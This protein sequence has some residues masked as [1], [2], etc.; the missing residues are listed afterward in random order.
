MCDFYDFG[1]VQ[2]VERV[3]KN[4]ILILNIFLEEEAKFPNLYVT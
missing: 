2:I 4:L 3:F 1:F